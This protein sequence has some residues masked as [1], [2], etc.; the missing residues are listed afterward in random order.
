MTISHAGFSYPGTAEE[1]KVGEWERAVQYTSAFAVKGVSQLDGAVR[2]RTL[3]ARQY[4]YNSFTATTLIAFIA[5]SDL[6]IGTVGTLVDNGLQPRTLKNVEFLGF[7]L[8]E[9]PLPTA[10]DGGWI[11]IGV[12]NFRQLSP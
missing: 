7:V 8:E 3:E 6:K 9:G 10:P 1:M 12:L 5:A 11:A 2:S 4:L